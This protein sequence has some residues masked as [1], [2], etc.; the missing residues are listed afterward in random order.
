MISTIRDS[1]DPL[2]VVD[3][4][5][6]LSNRS[7]EG[8]YK[9]NMILSAFKAM[10]YQAV[11]IGKDDFHFNTYKLKN[12]FE[13]HGIPMVT[14]NL[15]A[16]G[17]GVPVGN[18]YVLV[19][20]GS[21]SIAILSV[22]PENAF[23]N[24]PDKK[25][26][27]DIVDPVKAV[28]GLMPDIKKH[29]ADVTILLADFTLEETRTLVSNLSGAVDIA[30]SNEVSKDCLSPEVALEKP[31]VF[32]VSYRGM[33]LGMLTLQITDHGVVV[34][35]NESIDLG[36]DVPQDESINAMLDEAFREHARQMKELRDAQALRDMEEHFKEYRDLS[37]ME[38][39][40]K[41]KEQDKKD[42]PDEENN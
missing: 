30:I 23:D 33:W 31:Y 21:L 34:T 20:S 22:L 10:N 25:E 17:T 8:E 13:E 11:G 4:G 27:F 5:S 37:P 39:I 9:A 42:N 26:L 40:N 36:D 35:S 19:K 6:F 7:A 32:P 38:F 41:M 14:S 18:P 29:N 12:I 3:G 1:V 28:T 2:L 16:K 24:K 15:M